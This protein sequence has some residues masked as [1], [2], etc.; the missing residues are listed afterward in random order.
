MKPSVSRLPLF[1][2]APGVIILTGLM[3]FIT[4]FTA[5]GSEAEAIDRM[6]HFHG[7]LR[8]RY[9]LATE[10]GEER[11]QMRNARLAIDG[12]LSPAIDW[13]V[14]TDLCD[15]GT[16]KILDA[17]GRLE[18]A[19]G[20]RLQAGQFRLPFGTDCFKAP[21]N[22]LFANRSFIGKQMCNVRGV[23]AKASW[24]WQML[25][26][27]AGAFNPTSITDQIRW[28]KTL[29]YAGKVVVKPG[30]G[31]SFAAG[32]E[33]LVPDS[34][35]I[36]LLGAS[37]GWVCGGLTLEAEYMNKHY[38][39]NRH[40]AAHAWNFFADYGFPLK[41]GIFNRASVQARYDGMTAHSDGHRDKDGALVTTDPARNR[42]TVGAT[43]TYAWKTVHC[44]LR[45]DYEKYL[46]HHGVKAPSL[47]AADK[48][49]AE[50]VIRF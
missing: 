25:T 4:S 37:A 7:A 3:L 35:R 39:N 5:W 34:V 12:R 16:M 41:A 36:N 6:P 42:V 40:R 44:D 33:T 8:A 46:Y 10:G 38:V 27:E 28:V 1:Q 22:Y 30:A 20:L 15:R 14:Q 45:V 2:S 9:E 23:G 49:C 32:V 26:A 17:W 47:D 29:A 24:S 43:L 50:L 11:F 18:V 31:L 13:F 21:S 48:V 19:P